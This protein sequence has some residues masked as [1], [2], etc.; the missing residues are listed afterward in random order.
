MPAPS[1]IGINVLMATEGAGKDNTRQ[2]VVDNDAQ[3]D[4]A[5]YDDALYQW[6]PN[7]LGSRSTFTISK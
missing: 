1:D 3:E 7:F 6:F 2:G 4:T 5:D